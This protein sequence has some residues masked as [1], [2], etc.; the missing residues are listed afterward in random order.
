[1]EEFQE[2]EILWPAGGSDDRGNSQGDVVDD[3]GETEPIPCSVRPKA[4]A[5][6]RSAATAPVEISRRKR[7]CRPWRASE[8]Y[9]STTTPDQETDVGDDDKEEGHRSGEAKGSTTDGLVIVPPHVLVARRRLVVRG[10][11]AAAYSMCAG[12]GRTLKG[13]DLRD[14]RNQVLKMTGFIE[15]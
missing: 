7:R 2:A 12:K 5:P 3:G 9:T 6:P 8:H 13:R 10:R 4:A 11:T 1:M 14:V 15:E